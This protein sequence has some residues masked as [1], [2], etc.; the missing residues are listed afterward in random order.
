MFKDNF[1]VYSQENKGAGEAR[2]YGLNKAK[3]EY[4]YFFDA[5]DFAENNLCEEI[6]TIAEKNNKPDLI[7]FKCRCFDN[8]TK[9]SVLNKQSALNNLD[10]YIFN[11]NFKFSEYPNET[12]KIS[13][14]PWNGFCKK[15]FLIENNIFFI[16]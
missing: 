12:L 5:D 3:G 6:Y 7:K 13:V 16:T 1:Y 15:S 14:V 10:K 11:K 8:N 9:K 4:V 2:N